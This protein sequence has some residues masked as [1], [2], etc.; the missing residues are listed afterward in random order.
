MTNSNQC[1]LC[2]KRSI[3]EIDSQYYCRD[4]YIKEKER[5]Y[6]DNTDEDNP[7]ILK[8]LKDMYPEHFRN[9]F[10]EAHKKEYLRLLKLYDSRY[11]NKLHRLRCLI[12][13]RSFAKSKIIFGIISY[14]L[15][16]N[17]KIIKLK[18]Q[19]E[20]TEVRIFERYIVIFSETATMAE[21]FVM[22]IRDEFTSNEM[23]RYFYGN[24]VRDA[25][26][27]I[28]GQWT[29]KAFKYE[30]CILAGLGE[31]Q[32][33]RGRIKGAYRPTFVF[34]DDVYSENTVTTIDSRQ[35]V[36]NWFKNSAQNTLDDEIGKAYLVGTILHEDTVLVEA[37]QSNVWQTNIY[38]PM[39]IE[40]FYK[41]IK[42]YLNT[43]LNENK[44]NLPFE[45]EE[46]EFEKI[47]K[48]EDFFSQ[49]EKEKD[50]GLQWG[51]RINLYYLALKYKEAVEGN[52][53]QGFYQEYFHV[54][55]PMETKQFRAEYFRKLPPYELE[56]KNG[57]IWFKCK[58]LF[59][60]P[61]PII[62]HMGIDLGGY[63]NT[64]DDVALIIAGVLPNRMRI[65]FTA[66]YGKFTMRDNVQE[67]NRIDKVY[68][69]AT[70]IARIG[71]IDEAF[72]LAYRWNVSEVKIGRGGGSEGII[73]EEFNRIFR[74]NNAKAIIYE[75]PQTTAEGKKE[76]RIAKGLLPYYETYSVFHGAG[77][78]KLEFQLENL[79]RA[80]NDD[81]AD[82][83]EVCFFNM[84][85]PGNF[86]YPTNE[87]KKRIPFNQTF[88][89]EIEEY[90]Y[91]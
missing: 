15:T 9:N 64:S 91:I 12:A 11:K 62:M 54:I 69:D 5:R 78:E 2:E 23:I 10:S 3:A 65:I 28:D 16:H 74:T 34:Y 19:N 85:E 4:H 58:K 7:G 40:N 73:I 84:R 61:K 67:D 14:I 24:R 48:Q 42:Q 18:I 89:N 68:T 1:C 41:F 37:Q 22:N 79:G 52:G 77:L 27:S 39:D 46:N 53:L 45:D 29:K 49:L 47:K 76:E 21:D 72:R 8:W 25:I 88:K 44:C 38:Y 55:V 30:K 50:W 90:R 66:R 59:A 56:E 81:L 60:E 70:T 57:I 75:R 63:K 33:A 83:L 43:D 36:K 26:D 51:S 71:Y 80:K 82:G 31:G 13:F 20:I 87:T 6:C 32:Q 17:E 86:P 35:K